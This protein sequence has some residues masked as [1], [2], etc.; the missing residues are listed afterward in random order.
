MLFVALEILIE[1]KKRFLTFVEFQ[2]RLL[3]AQLP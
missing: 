2:F 1:K 3:A